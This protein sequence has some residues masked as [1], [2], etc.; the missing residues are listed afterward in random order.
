MHVMRHDRVV[1]NAIA[2]LQHEGAFPV[3]NLD[4][5]FQH[6]YVRP[7]LNIVLTDYHR[8]YFVDALMPDG[9]LRETRGGI[10]RADIVIVTKTDEP[11]DRPTYEEWRKASSLEPG[12][13]LFF[14]ELVYD[15]LEPLFPDEA[16]ETIDPTQATVLLISGIANPAPLLAEVRRRARQ[17]IHFPFAD[18]HSFNADELAR[19]ETKRQ[20]QSGPTLII[21]TE[22]DAARLRQHP[23]LPN[24][25]RAILYQ[26]PIRT[27]FL[28]GEGERFDLLIQRHIEQSFN[29]N[30]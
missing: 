9:R 12:Q 10:R 1:V 2:F 27:R 28:N 3:F 17:V 21:V 25:W 24:A 20:E 11:I 16:S 13:H 30:I 5:A 29:S 7:S 18:H 8:P 14:S 26:L 23:G 15:H 6:R 4:D 22:K 19:I